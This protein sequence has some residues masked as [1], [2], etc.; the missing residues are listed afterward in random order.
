MRIHQRGQ[1]LIH[2]R[3]FLVLVLIGL[4]CSL[5]FVTSANDQP[6]PGQSPAGSGPTFAPTAGPALSP[7]PTA[8]PPAVPTLGPTDDP[9]AVATS[10]PQP[11]DGTSY[12]V[13]FARATSVDAWPSIVEALGGSVDATVPA[14]RIAL[15]HLPDSIAAQALV[16][17]PGVVRVE[18]DQTRTAEG[19]PS[20][21]MFSDQWALQR[22]GWTEVY[23][24]VDPAAS[25]IVA[26][27]DTG[28]AADHP[29]LAGRLMPGRSYVD[30]VAADTDANGHGT[31]MAGIVGAAT[32]NATGIAGVAWGAVRILPITVLDAAGQGQDSAAIQGLVDAVDS[33]A[34]VVLMAFS[35][36]DYSRALQAAIDYAWAN[37]VVV[38]AAAGND[39]STSP[40]Y[41]AGDRGVIGVA[42]TDRSD[43]LAPGSNSGAAAFIGAP[44]VDIRTTYTD[45]A[46]GVVNGTSA[47][48]A[49][50]AGAAAL[51]RAVDP[52][53]TNGAVV[54]RLARNAAE[55]ALGTDVGNGRLDLARTLADHNMT[56]VEPEGAGLAG[57]GGPFLGP[58]TA[59]ATATWTGGG[60]DNNWSTAA[61][62]SDDTVPATTD[63]VIFD[64]TSTKDCTVDDV[65]TWSGGT[66]NVNSGYTGTVTQNVNITTGNFTQAVGTWTPASAVT[67][68]RSRSPIGF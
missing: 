40:A 45:G 7:I 15:I 44:G 25:T 54:G 5:P 17:A 9:T 27:L 39:G 65:G 13:T 24:A 31:W 52:A 58:Y 28:V 6:G 26:I 16:A 61:N 4:A 62:W 53:A 11:S 63:A 55:P 49:V 60:G 46:Y 57:N 32:D 51:V 20:D 8:D 36:P 22:I 64:G 38:V 34:D 47:A 2:R 1:P 30:G 14:L 23:G 48:A 50:V 59:A 68:D 21:A 10:T 43:G 56:A 42:S 29:D 66:L 35:S 3:A 67:L 12:I 33:G 37:D 41:P 19:I 18:E